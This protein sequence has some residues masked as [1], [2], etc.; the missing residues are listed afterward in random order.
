MTMSDR[1]NES[2]DLNEF[3]EYVE[4]NIKDYLPGSYQD[5]DINISETVRATGLKK[6]FTIKAP[7]ENVAQIIY[8][9]DFYNLYQKGQELPQ[10]MKQISDLQIEH[11][12]QRIPGLSSNIVPDIRKVIDNWEYAKENVILD[13][14]GC[15]KNAE[16]L[17]RHPHCKM[18]D[19]AAVYKIEMGRGENC[20]VAVP[21]TNEMKARYGVTT[22]EL[23]AQALKNSMAR[24]PVQISDMESMLLK[25]AGFSVEDLPE[26]S[27][28]EMGFGNNGLIVLSNKE[29][30]H[31]ASVLFYPGVLDQVSA[32]CPNGF[33]IIPSSVH[34]I[35][36]FPKNADFADREIDEIIESV[37]AEV[38]NPDE[39][40]SDFVHEYDPVG[41]IL[42]APSLAQNYKLL[43]V[44][45]DDVLKPETLGLTDDICSNSRST[46]GGEEFSQAV[47]TEQQRRMM[48]KY[49][50]R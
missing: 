22:E 23:H 7:N 43:E 13:T 12:E 47:K 38:V 1:I 2:M 40:L 41:K 10:V 33:Y 48:K 46:A 32:M 28:D 8:L 6:A 34:E 16:M 35:L 3:C 9:D 18:G 24:Y 45:K 27:M 15:T 14:A 30:F 5:W 31:G 20:R 4:M 42:Y 37:N 25:M 39:Q 36:I 50:G 21:V 26:I 17:A 44:N 19:I 49:A 29:A 11:D